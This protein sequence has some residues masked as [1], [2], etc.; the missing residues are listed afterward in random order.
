MDSDLVLDEPSRKVDSG[1][2]LQQPNQQVNS[3]LGL[4]QPNQQV[5]SGLVTQLPNSLPRDEPPQE[6]LNIAL[7]SLELVFIV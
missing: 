6:K 7:N 5:N 3:G 2:V 1:H 4:E